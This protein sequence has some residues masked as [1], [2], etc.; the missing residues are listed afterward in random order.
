MLSHTLDVADE[1]DVLAELI[2]RLSGSDRVSEL[3]LRLCQ[4][5]EVTDG[6]WELVPVV[7]AAGNA[8][9]KRS[10]AEVADNSP[11]GSALGNVERRRLRELA[12]DFS[13]Q[14]TPQQ[15]CRMSRLGTDAAND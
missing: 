15:I 5:L 3:A 11:A 13:Q 14:W 7:V 6:L 8:H 9:D 2:A 10:L 4:S 12:A 1:R